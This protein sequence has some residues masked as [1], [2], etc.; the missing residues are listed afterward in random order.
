[1]AK[2]KNESPKKTIKV[3]NIKSA[4]S[5]ATKQP[6]PVLPWRDKLALVDINHIHPKRKC[7]IFMMAESSPTYTAYID[8]FEIGSDQEYAHE[9]K[10][11]NY[12]KLCKLCKKFIEDSSMEFFAKEDFIQACQEAVAYIKDRKSLDTLCWRMP[13]ELM[14]KLLK[15]F[16]MY[17]IEK[18]I[19]EE[20]LTVLGE[21][22]KMRNISDLLRE[23][24]QKDEDSKK[25]KSKKGSKKKKSKDSKSKGSKSKDTKG[26]NKKSKNKTSKSSKTSGKKGKLIENFVNTLVYSLLINNAFQVKRN[27]RKVKLKETKMTQMMFV[28]T[29]QA[30]M[31][32]WI[33]EHLA[34]IQLI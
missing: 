34:N 25:G 24:V 10:S 21:Q 2:K 32:F 17:I 3:Q 16:I 33:K 11:I 23:G 5:S 29:S 15:F 12:E 14:A 31:M 9:L 8:M 19:L 1:M 4:T 13:R 7:I 26:K 20:E 28:K 27:T 6:N 30:K 22:N 18:D